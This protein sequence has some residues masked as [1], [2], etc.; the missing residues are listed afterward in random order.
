V[1]VD[2]VDEHERDRSDLQ[3]VDGSRR[4]LAEVSSVRQ[5][6]GSDELPDRR[7]DTRVG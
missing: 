6:I 2:P 1:P 5:A 4:M 3:A 7:Q